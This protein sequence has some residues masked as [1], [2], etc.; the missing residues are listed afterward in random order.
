M[1]QRAALLKRCCCRAPRRGLAA[2]GQAPHAVYAVQQVTRRH[3]MAGRVG[4]APPSDAVHHLRGGGLVS[5]R[6]RLHRLVSSSLPHREAQP[7][8]LRARIWR[9]RDCAQLRRPRCLIEGRHKL[10]PLISGLIRGR[11]HG[12]RECCSLQR[13]CRRAPC[14]GLV[15]VGQ[16]PPAVHVVQL[17]TRRHQT[18]G[19]VGQV[20]PK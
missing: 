19:R 16:A 17:V 6:C 20:L 11:A 3:Q 7:Q 10:C 8:A 2:V 14:R 18:A 4:Q 1:L 13:R 15:A 12:A 5:V 9:V